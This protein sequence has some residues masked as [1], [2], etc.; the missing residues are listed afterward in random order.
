MK[1]GPPV[2]ANV[3]RQTADVRKCRRQVG[4]ETASPRL[5]IDLT[6]FLL[7][8]HQKQKIMK[9]YFFG[10]LAFVLA[11][12]FAAFTTASKNRPSDTKLFK[13]NPPTQNPYS[14]INVTNPALWSFISEPENCPSGALKACQIEVDEMHV[15]PNNT[16]NSSVALEAEQTSTNVF[17]IKGGNVEAFTNR[18]D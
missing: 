3:K 17:R 13:Y 14:L 6:Y 11:I 10:I 2:T 5:S 16:L 18:G 9:N 7:L 1:R 15:N 8:N 12:G 4:T